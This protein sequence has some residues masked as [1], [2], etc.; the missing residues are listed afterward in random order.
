MKATANIKYLRTSSTKLK[1]VLDMIRGKNVED[2]EKLLKFTNKNVSRL[3]AKALHSAIAN[4]E[5]SQD[6]KDKG[7]ENLYIAEICANQGPTLKRF[8]PR[9]RGRA[10]RIRK[11]SSHIRITLKDI[12]V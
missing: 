9:A 7:L 2:A 5:Q 1:P 6:F 11:R 3:V 10:G 4:A 8:I 12:E